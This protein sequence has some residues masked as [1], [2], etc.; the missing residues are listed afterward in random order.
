MDNKDSSGQ[1][2]ASK[3]TAD[4]LSKKILG[5]MQKKY[6]GEATGKW[7][8]DIKA[9]PPATKTVLQ[10]DPLRE[11][12]I[13]CLDKFFD[14]FDRYSYELATREKDPI[15]VICNRPKAPATATQPQLSD[16]LV[17]F[18]GS[19]IHAQW[20]LVMQAEV[21]K[22]NAY[23][24]PA[25][26]LS[27]FPGRKAFFTTFMEMDAGTDKGQTVWTVDDQLVLDS[28]M[29]Y[30]SKKLFGSLIRVAG[31]AELR[32][33]YFSLNSLNTLPSEAV[34]D[35]SSLPER[36]KQSEHTLNMAFEGF[37]STI[38][39]EV[40]RLG[41]IGMKG[42]QTSDMETTRKSMKRG[43]ELKTIRERLLL[44]QE[45]LRHTMNETGSA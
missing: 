14:D 30:I 40:D 44:L 3:K 1:N 43:A 18:Q 4:D 7:M 31:G 35:T 41:A 17:I 25:E 42:L 27:A 19:V 34:Q 20:A 15:K 12:S 6:T 10:G 16:S 9:E 26:Y 21:T 29:S 2:P 38:D 32:N 33:E 5:S 23:I 39:H 28:M 13:V 45:E 36:L 22:I 37:M 8:A 24:V 11:S